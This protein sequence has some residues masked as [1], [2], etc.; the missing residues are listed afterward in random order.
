M[1]VVQCGEQDRDCCCGCLSHANFF[2]IAFARRRLYGVMVK[3]LQAAFLNI[4]L[5]DVF[6]KT[7]TYFFI[8]NVRSSTFKTSGCC[9][10]RYS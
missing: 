3:L 7:S 4:S 8:G 9:E 2:C 6:L 5:G 1:L 10:I